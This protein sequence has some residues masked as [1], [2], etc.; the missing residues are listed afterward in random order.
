MSAI[1]GYARVSTS[2]QTVENQRLEIEKAGF[3]MDYFM[4]DSISGKTA[5]QDRPAFRDLLNKLRPGETLIVSKLDRLG[6][7]SVDVL[8]TVRTLQKME[9]KV[10]VLQ[11]GA[12]DVTST[13]GKLLLAMLAAVAEMERDLIVERTKAGLDRARAQGRKLGRPSV[14]PEE[15]H[16]VIRQRLRDGETVYGIAKALG[17]N[18]QVVMRI[19]DAA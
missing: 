16:E 13:A 17:T 5:A 1:F 10:I 11:F 7:D 9:V 18:R 3:R 8:Q 14:I 15:Q 2:D 19:R 4:H 12:V 6:R